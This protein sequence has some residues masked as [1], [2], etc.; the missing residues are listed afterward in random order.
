MVEKLLTFLRKGN[1]DAME[2]FISSLQASGQQHAAQ[3][4]LREFLI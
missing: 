3:L 2:H 1:P 4:M